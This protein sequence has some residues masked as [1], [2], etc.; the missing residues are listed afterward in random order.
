MVAHPIHCNFPVSRGLRAQGPLH[1]P[2]CYSLSP[3][4]FGL[5][6]QC[7]CAKRAWHG[8]PWSSGTKAWKCLMPRG[9]TWG[10]CEVYFMTCACLNLA[11]GML[12]RG[13]RAHNSF[14]AEAR[15]NDLPWCLRRG[16]QHARGPWRSGFGFLFPGW[17][18]QGSSLREFRMNCRTF[19]V[20]SCHNQAQVVRFDVMPGVFRH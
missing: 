12:P 1:S 20:A 3:V 13:L 15:A 9:V 8:V 19:S 16:L 11:F 6:L 14:L 5:M 17:S 2:G 10:S 4:G 7:A 18:C